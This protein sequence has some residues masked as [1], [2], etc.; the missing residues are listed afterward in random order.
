MVDIV[1]TTV[2][3]NGEVRLPE[4]VSQQ[5][6][7]KPGQTIVLE[8][9]TPTEY[10]IRVEQPEESSLEKPDPIAALGFAK[11]HGLAEGTTEEWMRLIRPHYFEDEG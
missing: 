9:L 4:L 1:K 8:Q 5:L 10:H 6:E 7:L 2:P 3:E 11:K